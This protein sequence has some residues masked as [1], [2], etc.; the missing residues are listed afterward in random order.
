MDVRVN[1]RPE[2]INLQEI[3]KGRTFREERGGEVWM[4]CSRGDSDPTLKD[5]H[6]WVVSLSGGLAQK[7]LN[8]Q[9]YPVYGY[10]QEL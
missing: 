1:K 9:V 10:F 8:S 3:T 2:R 7:S 4:T 5:N 6:C